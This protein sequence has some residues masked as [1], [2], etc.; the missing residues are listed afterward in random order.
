[1]R[2]FVKNFHLNSPT[3]VWYL[4]SFC[5][6]LIIITYTA[7]SKGLIF[8][9]VRAVEDTYQVST[10]TDDA[11]VS[12]SAEYSDNGSTIQY[13]GDSSQYVG[14]RFQN[15]NIDQGETISSAY[16]QVTFGTAQ[17]NQLDYIMYAEKTSNCSTFSSGAPPSTRTATT[18]TVTHSSNV[19]TAIGTANLETMTSVIQEIVNQPSWTSGNSICIIIR[20]NGTQ[21]SRKSFVA[22]DG[23]NVYA[24][25]LIVSHGAA[26]PTNTP[27]PTNTPNPSQS[28]TPTMTP[29][30]TPVNMVNWPQFQFD[31]QHKARTTVQ[32]NPPYEVACA[33]LDESHISTGFSSATNTSI[34]DDAF[35]TPDLPDNYTF[36]VIVPERMQMI[37]AEGIVYFG[38]QNGK[39]YAV[40]AE[41][42]SNVWSYDTQS[43][44]IIGSPAY[45]SGH[46]VFGA[47]NGKIYDLDPETG[48]LQWSY[49]TAAPVVAAAVVDNGK[50]YIGSRSGVFYALNLSDGSLA[51]SYNTR[52][53]P[54]DST[55]ILNLMP[56]V[57]PAVVSEDSATVIFVAENLFAYALSTADGSEAWSPIKL[58]G[59]GTWYTFPVIVDGKVYISTASSKHGAEE[60]STFDTNGSDNFEEL[61]DGMASDVTWSTEKSEVLDY[62]SRNPYQKVWHVFNVS[63]GTVPYT[64]AMGRVTGNNQ[65]PFPPAVHPTY[66]P[67]LYWRSRTSTLLSGSTFGS[68]YCPDISGMDTS[69]G[70]RTKISLANTA[71]CPELDNGFW[72]TIG[73][74]ILYMQNPFRGVRTVNLSTGTGR[75]VLSQLAKFD[76]GD[77]RA[78]GY[79]V[80]LYGND[81]SEYPYEDD[82]RLPLLSKPVSGN[83]GISLATVNGTNYMYLTGSSGG[84]TA[85]AGSGLPL[86]ILK[87]NQ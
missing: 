77:F 6:L 68:D 80:I 1:M 63:D 71:P 46:L 62:L 30:P 39:M 70:D 49:Q 38:A 35:V 8:S 36:P 40:D 75:Y 51:W 67:M 25:K 5:I 86:L 66:G 55:S 4:F 22:Y 10:S 11:R 3:R 58:T 37:V 34:T 42:C 54:A 84:G 73:G 18:A 85:Q 74:S 50:V 44:G 33:W 15:V 14:I 45:S 64:L 65:A 23:S 12:E 21:F 72:L 41:D 13:G 47:L 48:D 17:W 60:T 87:T 19:N 56:I 27:T 52:V 57:A 69:T 81:D 82:I 28:P 61:L 43:L 7:S 29:S 16:V 76:Y 9:T 26:S 78:Q 53:E 79:D 59:Q 83:S 2:A 20:G 32:V 24:P 31:A